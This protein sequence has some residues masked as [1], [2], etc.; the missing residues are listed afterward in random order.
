MTKDMVVKVVKGNVRWS[1]KT[2]QKKKKKNYQG[3]IA[4]SIRL[5]LGTGRPKQRMKE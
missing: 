4:D 2:I 1:V 5:W 3:D